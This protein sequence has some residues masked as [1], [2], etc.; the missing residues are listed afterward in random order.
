MSQPKRKVSI[1]IAILS[2]LFL[3]ALFMLMA[4]PTHT[5]LRH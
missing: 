1:L 5:A 3:F 2:G 4:A